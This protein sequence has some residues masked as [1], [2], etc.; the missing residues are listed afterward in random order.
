MNDI[1]LGVVRIHLF[2]QSNIPCELQSVFVHKSNDKI[3]N[4]LN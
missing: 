4:K 1:E 2:E 3:F